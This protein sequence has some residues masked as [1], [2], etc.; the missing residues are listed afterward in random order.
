MSLNGARATA[1]KIGS[2]GAR[3]QSVISDVLSLFNSA[4][5]NT[6]PALGLQA[7]R[8]HS[9]QSVSYVCSDFNRHGVASVGKTLLLK[10]MGLIGILYVIWCGCQ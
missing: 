6:R 10:S 7:S 2:L 9:G 3:V 1:A 8:V 5:L 4:N